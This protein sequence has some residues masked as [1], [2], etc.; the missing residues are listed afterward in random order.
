MPLQR[1]FVLSYLAV[2]DQPPP[3]GRKSGTHRFSM[4]THPTK[5]NFN[6]E[7]NP[8]CFHILPALY[9]M[10]G[11]FEDGT[12][13]GAAIVLSFLFFTLSWQWD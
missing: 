7:F 3:V 13:A 8:D 1:K 12:P 9:W 4:Q 10:R 11:E 2:N 6:A 5:P